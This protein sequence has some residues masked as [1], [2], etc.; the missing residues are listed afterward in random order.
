MLKEEFCP[1]YS[2]IFL[3]HL[4]FF[5][6]FLPIYYSE[7][8]SVYYPNFI[9]VNFFGILVLVSLWINRGQKFR[10]I[11]KNIFELV[12]FIGII[13]YNMSSFYMNYRYL[14]WYE[15]QINITIS[16]LFF[17]GLL[18]S[19]QRGEKVSD[20]IID[21]LIYTIVVSNIGGVICYFTGH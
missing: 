10:I 12:F 1:K 7:V 18:L 17:L 2:E 16:L 19:S 15:D 3:K 8:D 21:F 11:R 9:L 6:L 4:I 20:R 14:W 5:A 13:L